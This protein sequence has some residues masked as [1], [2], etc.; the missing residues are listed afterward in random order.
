MGHHAQRGTGPDGGTGR[1]CAGSPAASGAGRRPGAWDLD[2]RIDVPLAG[3]AA[4]EPRA[5]V[6]EWQGDTLTVWAGTQGAFYVRDVLADAFGLSEGGVTVQSCRIGGAFGGKTICTVKSEAAA[7]ARAAGAPVKVQ[8]TRAQ[9]FAQAFHRPPAAHRIRAR[10]EG[11]VDHRLG[12]S[13]GVVS[14]PV[15]R[16]RRPC[17]DAARHRSGRRGRRRGTGHGRALRP[18]AGAD[19]L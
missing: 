12:S 19:G 7:L 8:W 18:W 15:H 11:G 5:A 9:E 1:G 10:L 17:L 2:L 13:A 4:S 14:Y 6:A 16:C 3:H